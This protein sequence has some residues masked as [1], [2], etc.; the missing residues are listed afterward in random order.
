MCNSCVSWAKTKTKK[1]E[2][3]FSRKLI[4]NRAG[5]LTIRCDECFRRR[6]FSVLWYN[7]FYCMW[8]K[9]PHTPG[10]CSKKV[11]YILHITERRVPKTPTHVLSKSCS[12]RHLCET[13]HPSLSALTVTLVLL[14]V[15]VLTVSQALLKNR[16]I[17]YGV[18]VWYHILVSPRTVHKPESR[19]Q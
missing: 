16:P 4:M 2:L 1:N 11:L 7:R 10:P 15:G 6:S 3:L 8:R 18:C 17:W 9:I 14:F 13:S 19:P 12:R 5:L